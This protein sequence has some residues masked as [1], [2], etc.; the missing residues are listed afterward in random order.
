M[1]TLLMI[2]FIAAF[3]GLVTSLVVLYKLLTEKKAQRL[4][5]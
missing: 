1:E 2:A 4:E 3:A 5:Y